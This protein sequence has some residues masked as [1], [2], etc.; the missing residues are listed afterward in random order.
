MVLKSPSFSFFLPLSLLLSLSLSSSSGHL[1]GHSKAPEPR[2]V[3]GGGGRWW[4]GDVRG[5]TAVAAAPAPPPRAPA[6]VV[7]AVREAA[8]SCGCQVRHTGP[9]L[10][11]C[12]RQAE[13]GG[14]A[15]V[16]FQAEV[17]Q[18][19]AGASEA[20]GVRYTRLWGAPLAFRHLATQISKEV[21]L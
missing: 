7:L 3:G 18:L 16:A 2:C 14:G 8:R 12:S 11:C 19:S 10:L 21:E 4:G 13:G 20:N 6:E 5:R 15:T 17:C 1:P 9:F